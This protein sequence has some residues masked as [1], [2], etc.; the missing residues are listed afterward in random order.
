MIKV[1]EYSTKNKIIEEPAF[2]WWD[3][4]AL[5]SRNRII[6]T[7]KSRYWIHN[8]KFGLKVPHI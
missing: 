7:V 8:H 6:N 1:A 4:I 5:K 2:S 3:K